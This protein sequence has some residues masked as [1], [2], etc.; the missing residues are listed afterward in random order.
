VNRIHCTIEDLVPNY[1]LYLMIA[2]G[3]LLYLMIMMFD[4]R[5]A[6]SASD[7]LEQFLLKSAL[8]AWHKE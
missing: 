7:D 4:G 3:I 5:E 8:S 1:I 2:E 6:I